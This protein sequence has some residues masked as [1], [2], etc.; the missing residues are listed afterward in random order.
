MK[1]HHLLIERVVNA[2]DA[3]DKT[4]YADQVWEIL[5]RSYAK[6]P[7]GFATASSVEEL[8]AKS[9]LWKMVVRNGRVT[10]VN[11]YKDQ[12]GRKSIA[13]GTDGSDQGRADYMMIKDTDIK[14]GRSWGEVS[15]SPERLLA[16]SG[17]TPMPAKFAPMLTGKKILSYN[18]DGIH[19]TRLING[20]PHEK[21]IYGVVQ[22]T[23]DTES[24]LQAMGVQLQD[25]PANFQKSS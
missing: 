19:Y 24:K 2:F 17:A 6:I 1:I 22:L 3:N 18:P 11:V 7:G 10:A 21:V 20:E 14:L 13:S 4:R 9:Q 15:G 23:P 25:L 5:Q 12:Y 16:R 8:I